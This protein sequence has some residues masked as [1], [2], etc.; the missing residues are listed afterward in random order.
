MSSDILILGKG[1]IGSRIQ[2]ELGASISEQRIVCIADVEGQIERFKP[3]VV[4]N[5]IG[6]TGASNVDDCEQDPQA[7]LA[8]N[9]FVPLVMAEACIRRKVRFVHLSSGCIYH[10]DY[11]KDQP[12]DEDKVPDFFELY[13]SRTKIYAERALL[14]LAE[15]HAILIPRLRIPLDDRPHPRNLLTKLL[16]F[17][18][19]IDAR[20]SVTYI[21]DFIRALRHLIS[22]DARGIFNVVNEGGLEY[23]DLLEVYQERRP[24]HAYEVIPYAELPLVRTNLL[25]STEKLKMSGF[26]VRPIK[27]VLEECVQKYLEY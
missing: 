16:R 20:N 5:C 7:T 8:A 12:I 26:C 11:A 23:R 17:K 24:D 18:K 21:P 2:E 10:F 6:H 19:V 27:E 13:Y 1:Y 4:I 14:P 25:L 22:V 9:T 15:K 3:R